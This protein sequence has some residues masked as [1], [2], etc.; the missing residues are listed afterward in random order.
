MLNFILTNL[1]QALAHKKNGKEHDPITCKLPEERS[2]IEREWCKQQRKL[3]RLCK[4]DEWC[5]LIRLEE[6]E[7]ETAEQSEKLKGVG[8]CGDIPFNHKSSKKTKIYLEA[9]KNSNIVHEAEKNEPLL[10]YAISTKN[11]NFSRVKFKKEDICGEGYIESKYLVKKEGQDTV[12]KVGP[13]LISIIQ[14]QWDQEE[15]L[16]TVNAEGTVSITGAIQEGKIDEIIIN[17]EEEIINSDNTFTYLLFVPNTGAEIRIIGNK[18]GKKVKE[19]NF[20]I[21]VGK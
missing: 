9:D 15:E 2:L 18:N 16:I 19:L 6:L 3:H 7:I 21:R 14:P 13:K 10:F 20:K 8:D 4:L 11:K 17:E 1:N 5:T 12:V